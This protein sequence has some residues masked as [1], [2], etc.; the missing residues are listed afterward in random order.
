MRFTQRI[1]LLALLVTCAHFTA[2]AIDVT[3]SSFNTGQVYQQ[4]DTL[5]VLRLY[6]SA[7]FVDSNNNLVIGGAVGGSNFYKAVTCTRDSATKIVTCPAFT[8]PSTLDSSNPTVTVTGV[9]YGGTTTANL[10][11]RTIIFTGWQIPAIPATTTYA[12]LNTYNLAKRPANPDTYYTTA[13]T[14]NQIANATQ[15]I[16]SETP[17]GVVNGVNQS[18]TLARTPVAGSVQLFLNGSL[19]QQGNCIAGRECYTISGATITHFLP[20]QSGDILTVIYRTNSGLIGN[21]TVPT[22]IQ[23]G[24]GNVLSIGSIADGQHLKRSGSILGGSTA[25][26]NGPINAKD[27][28]YNAAGDGTTDDTAALRAALAAAIAE[29]RSL[30]IPTGR[31]RLNCATGTE[32]LLITRAIE[33]YGDGMNSTQLI[34]DSSVSTS[35]DV[36]RISPPVTAGALPTWLVA[37]SRDNQGYSLHDFAVLSANEMIVQTDPYPSQPARDALVIDVSNANQ[38]VYGLEIARLHLGS[39]SRYGIHFNNSNGAGSWRNT[40]GIWGVRIFGNTIRNGIFAHFWGDSVWIQANYFMGQNAAIESWQVT[41]ATTLNIFGNNFTNRD[42]LIFHNGID[43][44]FENNIVELY[45]VPSTG[46][47]GAAVDFRGDFGEMERV[48][49]RGNAINTHIVGNALDGVRFDN[50]NFAHIDQNSFARQEGKS[51]IVTTAS[52][53]NP[54]FGINFWKG[55]G[56]Q[57]NGAD[58]FPVYTTYTINSEPN[59]ADAATFIPNYLGVDKTYTKLLRVPTLAS[60]A[61][62]VAG[63]GLEGFGYSEGRI[64]NGMVATS[65]GSGLGVVQSYDRTA[66]AYRD[67]FIGGNRGLLF[68]QG[69][70]VWDSGSAT[71]SAGAA[72][73]NKQSGTITSE[74]LTTAAGSDYVLTLTNSLISTSSKVFVTVDNGSNTTEGISPQRTTPGSGSVVIRIRNTHA[75]AALNGTIKISFVVF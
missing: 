13:Q 58:P 51:G 49:F 24:G 64:N 55:T 26:P 54:I 5:I 4:S 39:F 52:T 36:I 14:D 48:S 6:Y 16:F 70:A 19:Q 47:N 32:C 72:T 61:L 63:K 21:G 20:P 27:Y 23:E 46:S 35:K 59:T 42:G 74:A 73:L 33:I 40:D 10:A 2:R 66:D 9:L 41:G 3:V 57:I 45:V 65:G 56:F 38:Y 69:G 15:G 12:T 62:P 50:V 1:A 53:L 22:Q 29:R 68:F 17:S 11:Q 25:L 7:T 44:N 37:S 34:I 60:P 75:N 71:A 43:L 8:L 31:Y 28:P 18:F 67:L 30:Y